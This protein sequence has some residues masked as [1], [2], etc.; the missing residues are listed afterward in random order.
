M[1]TVS[2]QQLFFFAVFAGALAIILFGAGYFVGRADSVEELV[3]ALKRERF[4]HTIDAALASD[5]FSGEVARESL[6]DQQD[7]TSLDDEHDD[8]PGSPAHETGLLFVARLAGFGKRSAADAYKKRVDK[9]D[10][11]S[12]VV[13]RGHGRRGWY[14]VVTTAAPYNETVALVERLK[15]RR[16][17][18]SCRNCC[19][20]RAWRVRGKGSV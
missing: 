14:Q 13:Q 11:A 18:E 8:D 3:D 16:S 7:D 15:K 9:K 1:S 20:T 12:E 17:F 6:E 19:R 2:D 4:A 10:I 5:Q